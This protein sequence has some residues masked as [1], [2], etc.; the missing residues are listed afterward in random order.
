MTTSTL[1]LCLMVRFQNPA[2]S[3]LKMVALNS[4]EVVNVKHCR[5]ISS[6]KED[7]LEVKNC[8]GPVF[9]QVHLQQN[10]KVKVLLTFS[11]QFPSLTMS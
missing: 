11:S 9:A 2:F 8:L 1:S 3:L 6:G 10:V 5:I 4:K 7:Y